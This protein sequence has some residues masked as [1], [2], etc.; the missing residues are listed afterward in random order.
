MGG[1]MGVNRY[2]DTLAD[3]FLEYGYAIG[4]GIFSLERCDRLV[5][6]ANKLAEKRDEGWRPLMQPHRENPLFWDA[7][8]KPLLTSQ[9]SNLVAGEVDALQSEFFFSPPGTRGFAKHQDNFF[10][11][12]PAGTFAS[13][14]IALTDI[15]QHQHRTALTA[16]AATERNL[17][18]FAIPARHFRVVFAQADPRLAK[19]RQ[20]L[21]QAVIPLC[22]F[23]FLLFVSPTRF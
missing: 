19:Q 16:R 6:A 12:A 21:I 9:I 23:V 11:E 1:W 5:A 8:S 2:C 4:R 18:G 20:G 17:Q 13:A 3:E 22:S 14:W 10:V 7:L 15:T